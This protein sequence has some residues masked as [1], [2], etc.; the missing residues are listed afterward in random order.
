MDQKMLEDVQK[1]VKE[2]SKQCF[3]YC[4]ETIDGSEGLSR[5]EEKCIRDCTKGKMLLFEQIYC[6]YAKGDTVIPQN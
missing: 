6:H 4:L 3:G 5:K 2:I 1:S